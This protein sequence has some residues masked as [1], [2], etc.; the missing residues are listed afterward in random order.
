MQKC[1][2]KGLTHGILDNVYINN[3]KHYNIGGA[4]LPSSGWITK[5]ETMAPLRLFPQ[6]TQHVF[7][8]H[9]SSK[10][11]I[12][13]TKY[14]TKLHLQ[15]NDARPLNRTKTSCEMNKL[16]VFQPGVIIYLSIF[17]F[18]FKKYS[19]NKAYNFPLCEFVVF[20]IV[21]YV[22]INKMN[23]IKAK[24]IFIKQTKTCI[25]IF[26]S[27]KELFFNIILHL[28]EQSN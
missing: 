6:W 17:F 15:T 13:D 22:N 28:S 24:L 1:I 16:I 2:F 9:T 27:H 10:I 8:R 19:S 18:F 11:H 7:K 21:L 12:Q 25:K 20:F 26:I 14:Q 3:G 23:N 4:P 5:R